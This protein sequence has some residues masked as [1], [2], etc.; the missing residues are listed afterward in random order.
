MDAR[1]FTSER[2]GRPLK[3]P[4]PAGYWYFLPSPLPPRITWSEPLVAALSRADHALGE[5]SSLAGLLPSPHLLTRPFMYHE[6]VLSSRI[7][8]TRASLSDLYT[9]EAG[10]LVLF[11]MSDD[12]KEVHNYTVALRYGLERVRDLP[13]SLRLLREMHGRLLAGVRGERQRPG[14]FRSSQNWIGPV[15][16]T[17]A[18]APYVPPPPAQMAECLDAFEK[19]LHAPSDLP[20]LVRIALAHYQFEAIHPFLDGNGRIGRLLIVVLMCLWGLLAEPLL[21]LS[22]YFAARRDEYLDRLLAVSRHGAWEEWLA[23]FCE[24]VSAQADDTATRAGK[25]QR[26]REGYRGRVGITRMAAGLLRAVDLLF[27]Q[28]IVSIPMVRDSLQ[29]SFPTAQRYADR[30]RSAGIVQEMTGKHR[31]RLYAAAEVLAILQE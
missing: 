23:F 3:T 22:P 2:A 14:E 4:G 29:V 5:V 21:Y 26:L 1:D 6:A 25:L 18:N 10:N 30:L 24:A 15:G 11:E 9:Y 12:V 7:E 31:N 8:G 20:P 27:T 19:W 16:S 13:L 28:P 17:P